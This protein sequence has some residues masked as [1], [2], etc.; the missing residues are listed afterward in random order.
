[1]KNLILSAFL[2]ALT[3]TSCIQDEAPNSEADITACDVSSDILLRAPVVLN[4]KVIVYVKEGTDLSALTPQFSLTDGATIAPASGTARDFTT[5]QQYTV[6]SQDG[7]WS[8]QYTVECVYANTVT[9]YHF[10][11]IRYCTAIG[12]NGIR[13]YQIFSDI[14]A[15][16]SSFEWGSGNA[17]Y[18]TAHSSAAPADYPTCQDDNGY[19][20]K[21]VK[22]TTCDTGSFGAQFGAP[23]AAGNLFMGTFNINISNMEKSTHFGMPFYSVPKALTGYY[24][25]KAGDTYTDAKSNVIASKKD[26]FDIY[27]IFYEVTA[28]VQ[29]LDGTNALTSDNIVALARISERKEADTWTYFNIPFQ[30]ISGKT[31]DAEK[32]KNGQYNISIILSS[33]IDGGKFNGAV[34]STLRVDE[35]QLLCE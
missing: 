6:T 26:S 34:G 27:A 8:K 21:C 20:G 22:L 16:G 31:I 33:S 25:Y 29:Y 1:M 9:D 23:I 17:G 14:A 3:L 32:L 24:K 30:L 28:D 5:P 19:V 10:E 35:M 18:K 12:N 4:D 7:K 15:D 13:F 11:S 2:C